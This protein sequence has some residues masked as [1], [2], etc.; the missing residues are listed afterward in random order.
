MDGLGLCRVSRMVR[1]QSMM[2]RMFR[3]WTPRRLEEGV[4]MVLP[5]RNEWRGTA[6]DLVGVEVVT[7]MSFLWV[8]RIWNPVRESEAW[9]E[10][11]EGDVESLETLY[12]SKKGWY[13]FCVCLAAGWDPTWIL[14]EAE[15][16]T[17]E[18]GCEF[19]N[20]GW[21]EVRS[22][23]VLGGWE[24]LRM[25]YQRVQT[26]VSH[27]VANWFGGYEHIQTVA[28]SLSEVDLG[29][30]WL[31]DAYYRTSLRLGP[32]HFHGDHADE[33]VEILKAL[34]DD[35]STMEDEVEEAILRREVAATPS[36]VGDVF[37]LFERVWIRV[38][39]NMPARGGVHNL[40][41]DWVGVELVEDTVY[42]V[43][44]LEWR[45]R[46]EFGGVSLDLPGRV[47]AM[48]SLYL[49]KEGW[50]N[51]GLALAAG[52]NPVWMFNGAWQVTWR[53]GFAFADPE[54]DD[55]TATVWVLEVGARILAH[56]S[57]RMSLPPFLLARLGGTERV[58]QAVA[59]LSRLSFSDMTVYQE[60]DRAFLELGPFE[61]DQEYEVLRI[62]HVVVATK[63]GVPTI[64]EETLKEITRREIGCGMTYVDDVH[65]LFEE[66]IG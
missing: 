26:W 57:V 19:A 2:K 52:G 36:Y 34:K 32:F 5:T 9:D 63:P 8:E 66:V 12:L 38:E 11:A 17:W 61:E 25:P 37:L 48:G 50:R 28:E 55:V 47:H 58:E 14:G 20:K 16:L 33:V 1:E 30:T 24:E 15:R 10:I 44:E 64:A 62:L 27:F 31:A 65:R 45:R 60:Y 39:V 6:C 4:E 13:L 23:V 49:S 53:E 54:R 42:L 40:V 59:A 43:V 22:R 3:G 51:F 29:F 7:A 46:G 21:D 41:M 35:R 56:E 18:M